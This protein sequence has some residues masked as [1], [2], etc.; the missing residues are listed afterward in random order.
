MG[1]AA[2]RTTIRTAI[3]AL[4][5]AAIAGSATAQ[6][7]QTEISVEQLLATTT[8]IIGEPLVYPTEGQAEVT[9]IIVTIPPGVP[10]GWHIHEAPLFGYMLEGELTVDYGEHGMHVYQ[11]GD[12][13]MEAVGWPHGGTST[14]DVPARVL[15]V[16]MGSD[17]MSVSEH[18]HAPSD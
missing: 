15:V 1:F 4:I 2:A 13:L 11:Q 17:G 7:P 16:F 12:S 6:D 3:A 5:F 18:V 9:A 8:T 10:T 14:G